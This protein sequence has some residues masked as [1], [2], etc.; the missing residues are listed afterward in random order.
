MKRNL[1]KIFLIVFC[2]TF[3]FSAVGV[4]FAT[5]E[6]EE[7]DVFTLGIS[8]F[9]DSFEFCYK[10]HHNIEEYA[11]KNGIKTIYAEANMEPEKIKANIGAASRR[12]RSCF[13]TSFLYA[14]AEM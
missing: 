6:P 5:D 1:R 13:L 2:F 10:V 7:E 3:T 4:V 14:K 8:N 9:R 11:A 12:R